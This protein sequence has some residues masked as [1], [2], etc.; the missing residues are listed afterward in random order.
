[1]PAWLLDELMDRVNHQIG[2]P[3]SETRICRGRLFSPGDYEVDVR[4][5]GFTDV[6]GA[7]RRQRQ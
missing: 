2:L 7:R 1:V 4:E 5:W 6:C 3:P